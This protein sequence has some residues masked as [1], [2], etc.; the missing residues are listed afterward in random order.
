MNRMERM[1]ACQHDD[2]L[3]LLNR[4]QKSYIKMT[5]FTKCMSTT[6]AKI[7]VVSWLMKLHHLKLVFGIS[8]R[9]HPLEV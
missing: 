6:I 7:D 5:K 3:A 1:W 8:V 2:S 9:N 4:L